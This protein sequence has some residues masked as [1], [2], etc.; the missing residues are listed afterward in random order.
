MPMA[1][2]DRVQRKHGWSS[3]SVWTR[4]R[5]SQSWI[6]KAAWRQRG[7]GV[8]E[9]Q[10]LIGLRGT[11]EVLSPAPTTPGPS[12]HGYAGTSKVLKG[13][14]LRAMQSPTWMCHVQRKRR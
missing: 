8:N 14:P 12:A 11:F 5:M 3:Y 9:V 13:M 7:A 10:G 1:P 2:A 6:A 4:I